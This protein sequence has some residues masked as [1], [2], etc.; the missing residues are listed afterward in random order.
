ML[1]PSPLAIYQDIQAFGLES[2]GQDWQESLGLEL[3]EKILPNIFPNLD[4]DVQFQSQ[5]GSDQYVPK[6]DSFK[7]KTAE[8]YNRYPPSLSR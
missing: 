6:Y 2:F 3:E 5:V 7:R 8:N 1:N 4:L